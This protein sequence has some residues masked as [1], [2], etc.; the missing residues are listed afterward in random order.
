VT[1]ERK[2]AGANGDPSFRQ[3]MGLDPTVS[4][5]DELDQIDGPGVN[6]PWREY[7]EAFA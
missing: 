3:M 5:E 2:F 1:C 6:Y 7:V 4:L